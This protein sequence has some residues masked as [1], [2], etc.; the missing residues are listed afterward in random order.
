MRPQWFEADQIP[1]DDMWP[2]DKL[3]F[4]MLLKGE[5]FEGYFKFEGHNKMLDYTLKCI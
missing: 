2:D 5:K 1:F 3:W 4:P